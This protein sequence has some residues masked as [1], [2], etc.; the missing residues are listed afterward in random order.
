VI[1][2]IEG[3]PDVFDFPRD[4]Q[5]ILDRHCVEC[6]NPRRREGGILLS[7][8]HG[9]LYSHSYYTLTYRGQFVDGRND[10][11]SNLD[12]YTIGAVA[13]PLMKKLDGG[14]HGVQASAAELDMVRYWIET[15][16]PYPGTYAALGSGMIGGYHENEQVNHP[17][18]D[19]PETERAIAAIG[20]RCVSCHPKIPKHLSD[21]SR[22]SFW[23][24]DWGDPNLAWTRHIV[25][26]LTEPEQSLMLLAPL[27]KSAGGDG[28]CEAK[29]RQQPADSVA[30]VSDASSAS[31]FESTSDA[32]YQ[33]IL[34][35]I[36]R[37]RQSLSER[38][39]FDMPGFQPTQQ[40][41]REMKRYGVLDPDFTLGS[42]PMDVY[43]TDR[44]YW[45]SLWHRP[46]AG[47][48]SLRVD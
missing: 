38:K 13:S 5:P 48:R 16:A 9:P 44:A 34:A 15:G 10:P 33:A 29:A 37:G 12:P 18:T 41:V 11:K 43:E 23:R 7:G 8:D 4:I 46:G 45:R 47:A 6:H 2:P 39:R 1:E 32:D 3:V 14:H 20:R 21:N 42:D 31:V 27:A 26:N 35:M 28:L 25:F 24:P 17:G 22:I 19:W 30:A 36:Q 40:Y